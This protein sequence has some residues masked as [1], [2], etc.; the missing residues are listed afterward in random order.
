MKNLLQLSIFILSLVGLHSCVEDEMYVGPAT[1]VSV[2]ATPVAPN[3]TE[4]VTVTAKVTDLK[5][6]TAV[7]LYYKTSAESTFKS[8][9]MQAASEK[10]MYTGVIPAYPKDTTVQYYVEANNENN[11]TTYYPA[12]APTATVSYK[13][14]ASSVV[15]LFIN[16][17][18]ADGTKDSTDPDWVEVYNDSDIEV[19]LNGYAFYDDG[20]KASNGA[21]PK[22]ILGDIKIPSKGFVSIPTEYNGETVTFGLS[23]SGDAVY[24]ENQSGVLV[25]S[26]DFNGISL[27]GKKSYGRK[28]DASSTFVTFANPTKAASNNNAN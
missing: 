18:F 2:A 25:T 10:F 9:D 23:T 21:K 26:L 6:V 27:S 24:L 14:G 1:I 28:P 22:R 5:G 16:E 17:A 15:K 3:S 7:K 11:L 8:V 20:I 13:V 4:T 19:S 12:K